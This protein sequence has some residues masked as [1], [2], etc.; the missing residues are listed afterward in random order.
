[1]YQ[2][3]EWFKRAADVRSSWEH[4]GQTYYDPQ[5]GHSAAIAADSVIGALF[6]GT[7]F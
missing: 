4:E 3:V 7:F 5:S 6:V 1:M 2:V